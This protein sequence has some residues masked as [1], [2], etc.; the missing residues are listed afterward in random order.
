MNKS[1][2]VAASADDG[3]EIAG[4]V[5]I[6]GTNG[7]VSAATR[8]AGLSFDTAADPLAAGEQIASATLTYRPA[9]T[10]T[11]DPDMVWKGHKVTNSGQYTTAANDISNRYTTNPTTANATD[12]GASVGT[13][14]RTIDVTAIVQELVNQA[15]TST[16]RIGL[17]ARGNAGANGSVVFWD[18]G[19]NFATLDV[20][21][22]D[23]EEG[24]ELVFI[25]TGSMIF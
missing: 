21:T 23:A 20:V 16:S 1:Y 9:S 22:V 10:A 13:G 11:D 14:P 7:V 3:I 6:N 2:A 18:N 8:Y 25:G 17:I 4:A 15:W 5:T 12:V 24:A 19:S